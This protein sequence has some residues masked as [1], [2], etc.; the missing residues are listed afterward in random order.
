V[1]VDG[2]SVNATGKENTSAVMEG[3]FPTQAGK[4]RFGILRSGESLSFELTAQEVTLQGA[5]HKVLTLLTLDS[6]K[7]G[8]LLFNSH[9]ESAE[10][11]LIQAAT[12]FQQEG[13][14]ELVV[15][16][17]YNTGGQ[18]D[19]ASALAGMVAGPS[20]AN[21]KIFGLYKFSDK[22]SSSNFRYDFVFA[23]KKG[24]DL[25]VLNLSKIYVLTSNSTCSASEAFVNGLRGIDVEVELIGS[26]TCGKPYGFYHQDNCG[27]TYAAMEL[28]GVNAKG[29]GGYVDGIA[30]RCDVAD[31]LSHPLG[32]PAEAML[33]VALRR[34]QG[35]ACSQANALGRGLSPLPQQD[36][37]QLMRP[38]WQFN[39]ILRP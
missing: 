19:I 9:I 5:E 11:N 8:Y 24:E 32:D 35:Q 20:R 33:A 28:E 37:G 1:S 27:I 29:E 3:L 39:K 16:L 26:T 25:P 36:P 15:D 12:E 31:D 4:H 14:S 6:K 10:P 13:V 17:R 38:K 7:I 18:V 34:M 21:G 23:S 2:V 22:R 30:P